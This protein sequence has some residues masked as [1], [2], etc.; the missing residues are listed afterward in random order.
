MTDR[1]EDSFTYLLQPLEGHDMRQLKK[2]VIRLKQSDGEGW[3]AGEMLDR[4]ITL[5]V[6]ARFFLE[7]DDD[8]YGGHA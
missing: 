4:A 7:E 2:V 8:D 1:F 6:A 3:A 5:M